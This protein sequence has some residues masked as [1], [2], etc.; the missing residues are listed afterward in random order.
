[1]SKSM[2]ICCYQVS[3]VLWRRETR[4]VKSW[5]HPNSCLMAVSEILNDRCLCSAARG[6]PGYMPDVPNHSPK[7][8]VVGDMVGM[9]GRTG[10]GISLSTQGETWGCAM[11]RKAH[12][13]SCDLAA[14]YW[15]KAYMFLPLGLGVPMVPSEE[16]ARVSICLAPE[17][18]LW[19][20]HLFIH[21]FGRVTWLASADT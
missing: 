18:W 12:A 7:R 3:S 9:S 5:E 21:S 20:H 2:T 19:G 8:W 17:S 13:P 6:A 4:R 11:G 16:I 1:M 15:F 10:D 14:D